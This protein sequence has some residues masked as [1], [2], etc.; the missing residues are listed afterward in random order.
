MFIIDNNSSGNNRVVVIP[1]W[2]SSTLFDF[3][4]VYLDDIL[5][6]VPDS[7]AGLVPAEANEALRAVGGELDEAK[8]QVWRPE[9]GCPTGCGA[10]WQPAGLELLGGPLADEDELA[11]GPAPLGSTGYV[12]GFLNSKLR[13]FEAFLRA[14]ERT[15]VS[16]LR[17]ST[18]KGYALLRPRRTRKRSRGAGA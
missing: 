3:L 15:A 8:S 4:F 6:R 13:R 18:G 9:G 14:V 12:Q 5:V 1:R 2:V 10:W 11:V 7:L 17:K 16:G